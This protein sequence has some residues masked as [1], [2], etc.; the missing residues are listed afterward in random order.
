MTT[1]LKNTWNP[2]ANA[3][4]VFTFSLDMLFVI[5]TVFNCNRSK[6]NKVLFGSTNIGSPNGFLAYSETGRKEVSLPLP[7]QETLAFLSYIFLLLVSLLCSFIICILKT[8]IFTGQSGV[9]Q[10]WSAFWLGDCE[11][12]NIQTES[13]WICCTDESWKNQHGT[14][15]DLWVTDQKVHLPTDYVQ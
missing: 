15:G 3:I 4:M 14:E 8:I 5:W 13:K 6:P 9:C 11:E 7:L 10:L 1:R 2:F 12:W